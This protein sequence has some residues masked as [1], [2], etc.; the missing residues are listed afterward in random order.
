MP[1]T[2]EEIMAV[3]EE[4]IYQKSV[5]VY[6]KFGIGPFLDGNHA[7]HTFEEYGP[8][9]G[10]GNLVSDFPTKPKDDEDY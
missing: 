2:H 4:D 3:F 5:Q 6:N 10:D 1:S 8:V 9:Y 7:M